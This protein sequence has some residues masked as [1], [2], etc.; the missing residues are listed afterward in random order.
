[1]GNV[2]QRVSLAEQKRLLV[3]VLEGRGVGPGDADAQ[4]DVLCEG[5]LRGHPSHGLQR[6]FRIVERLDAGLIDP[7]ASVLVDRRSSSVSVID[8]CSALGAVAG[9]VAIDV[10][11]ESAQSVG[12]GLVAM[13]NANHLGM[14]APYVEKAA[15]ADLIAL[16]FTTSEALV[17]PFAGRDALIGTNPIAI[18]VPADPDPFVLDMATGIVS[19]GKVIAYSLAGQT[20]EEGWALD[21]SGEPTT[22]P[23]QARTGAISPFGGAKGYGLGLAI[24]VLVASLTASAFGTDVTGTLDATWPSTKGDL[25]VLI[26]PAVLGVTDV[27]GRVGRYL[28][29]IRES[30]PASADRPVAVPG[31]RARER[32][33]NAIDAGLQHPVDLWARAQSLLDIDRPEES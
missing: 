25:F 19:M 28:S 31:D 11:T 8:G 17:H 16:A 18:A 13:R 14:L 10:G 15:R 26:D 33:R 12:V 7:Q 9:H 22:D 1:M 30:T 2:L 20:L 3:D 4:A 29:E 32:R 27:T 24:E 23:D 6:I 5:D 21:G